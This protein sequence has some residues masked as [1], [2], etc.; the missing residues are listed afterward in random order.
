MY[1]SLISHIEEVAGFIAERNKEPIHHESDMQNYVAYGQTDGNMI[2]G[3]YI[4]KPGKYYLY[5]YK[6]DNGNGA[7]SIKVK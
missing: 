6:F 4:V 1:I 5:V 2:K 7:Y 3:K